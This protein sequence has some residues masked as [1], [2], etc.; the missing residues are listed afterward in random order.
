MPESLDEEVTET[1]RKVCANLVEDRALHFWLGG[2][3]HLATF[4]VSPVFWVVARMQRC[5]FGWKIA[6]DYGLRE[7]DGVLN[8]FQNLKQFE[9]E[10]NGRCDGDAPGLPLYSHQQRD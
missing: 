2:L 6:F 4:L 9:S 1:G 3:H 10:W 7:R 8:P 5:S